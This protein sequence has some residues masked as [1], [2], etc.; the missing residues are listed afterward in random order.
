MRSERDNNTILTTPSDLN[1]EGIIVAAPYLTTS[2][3][4]A[5]SNFPKATILSNFGY[6]T[7]YKMVFTKE[8]HA[9]VGDYIEMS[10]WLEANKGNCSRCYMKITDSSQNFG[11]FTAKFSVS[12]ARREVAF[13]MESQLLFFLMMIIGLMAIY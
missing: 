8:V 9:V 1:K 13:C 11:S 5:K 4:Y 3:E 7:A 10:E 6:K 12:S 2:Y